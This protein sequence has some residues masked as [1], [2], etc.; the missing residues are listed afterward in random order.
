M[1]IL[2]AFLDTKHALQ[3]FNMGKKFPDQGWNISKEV[4]HI[5]CKYHSSKRSTGIC[6]WSPKYGGRDN[7]IMEKFFLYSESNP[8]YCHHKVSIDVPY[9]GYIAHLPEEVSNS[10]RSSIVLADLAQIVE[11][12]ICNSVDAGATKMCFIEVA[13]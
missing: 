13:S 1:L 3:A 8:K 6:Q 2:K 7:P 9:M 5:F 11:E 4:F 10:L 12:L